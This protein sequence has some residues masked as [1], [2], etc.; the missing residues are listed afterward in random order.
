MCNK[1]VGHIQCPFCGSDDA[2]VHVHAK[3]KKKYYVRC[4]EGEGSNKPVCGTLQAIG[5]TGQGIIINKA[6]FIKGESP[7]GA[8]EIPEKNAIASK[9]PTL[10]PETVLD[11]M[12]PPKRKTL[13]D[14]L[15]GV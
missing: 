13:Y 8:I 4:Y 10:E 5:P 9:V 6:R 11:D 12:P 3:G 14:I 2:T 15:I 7:I 1:I